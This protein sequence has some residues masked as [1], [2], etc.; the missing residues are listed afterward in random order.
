MYFTST[1]ITFFYQYIYMVLFLFNNVIY[2]FL[3][4][5]CVFLPY[6]YV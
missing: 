2:V 5:D 4:Y 1:I 6:V 3:L